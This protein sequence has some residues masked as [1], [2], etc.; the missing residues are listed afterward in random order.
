[1]NNLKKCFNN[2]EKYY[3]KFNL[4]KHFII[5]EKLDSNI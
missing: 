1:M 5:I 4:V 2:K 3:K